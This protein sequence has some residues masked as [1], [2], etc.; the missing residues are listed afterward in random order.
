[1][2]QIGEFASVSFDLFMVMGANL[3]ADFAS[4]YK[5]NNQKEIDRSLKKMCK[6][7]TKVFNMESSNDIAY[8]VNSIENFRLNTNEYFIYDDT[9][10][11]EEY[12]EKTE[13]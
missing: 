9:D 3:T 1:M 8:V 5:T 7:L 12:Y 10:F 2:E 4:S 6:R 13:E 11:P